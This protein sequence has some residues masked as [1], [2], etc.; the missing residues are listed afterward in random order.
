[1]IHIEWYTC[2]CVHCGKLFL[3]NR[4]I[5]DL[6]PDQRFISSWCDCHPYGKTG[7]RK[8]PESDKL[9]AICDEVEV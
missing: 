1:M 6:M 8:V 5:T 4:R 3:L 9:L 2:N 7:L